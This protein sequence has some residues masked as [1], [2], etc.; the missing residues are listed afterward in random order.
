M[1]FY[2]NFASIHDVM[3]SIDDRLKF[4]KKIYQYFIKKFNIDN[5]IDCA[6]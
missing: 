5:V 1:N 6:C 2:N 3:L 4:N